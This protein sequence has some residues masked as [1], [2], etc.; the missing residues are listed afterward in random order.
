MSLRAWILLL[1][2]A[3]LWGASYLFIKVGLRDLSPAEIA[4]IRTALGALVLVPFVM[5]RGAVRPLLERWR[6]IVVLGAIH[7]AAPFLLINA[8]EQHISS[9]LTGIL[10]ASTPLFTALFAIWILRSERPAARG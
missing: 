4:V 7:V 3:S 8:G 5:A 2:L 9:S 6:F 10:V 1:V